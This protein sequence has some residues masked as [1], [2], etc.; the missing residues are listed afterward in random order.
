[1]NVQWWCSARD[2]PWNWTW[3]AYPGVWLFVVAVGALFWPLRQRRGSLLGAAGVPAATVLLWLTLDYPVGP[4][5]AG[6]LAWVHAVQFL[7]LAMVVPPLLYL[8]LDR[9]RVATALERRGWAMSL[10]RRATQPLFAMIVFAIVMVV[11]HIPRVV[12]ALMVTQPGA[13]ALDLAW[14]GA[15]LLF[16]WP[17][18]VRV[19]ERPHFP[20]LVQML[21]LF[22]G[23]QP[24]LYIAMWL[25]LARFPVYGT[26]ELAPRV[27]DLSAVTDQQIAGGVML[28]VGGTFILVVITVLFFRWMSGYQDREP[29]RRSG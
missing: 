28:G 6:Y 22:F 4:L 23:A 1:V 27:G 9:A 5:G 2:L 26:Y 24:H 3:Q 29:F 10:V 16:W 7:M 15:G 13:F 14:L 18:L 25:L 12:D 21:Y 20:P 8:G 11:S 19:P 17:V